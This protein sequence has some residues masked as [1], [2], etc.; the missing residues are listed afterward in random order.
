MFIHRIVKKIVAKYN[1]Y[2]KKYK[3]IKKFLNISV[4]N[5][6]IFVADNIGYLYSYDYEKNKILWAKNIKLDLDQ[7]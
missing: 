1:F 7:I 4:E 6:I 2:K 3:K 5:N